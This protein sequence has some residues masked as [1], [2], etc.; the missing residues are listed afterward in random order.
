MCVCVHTPL[1]SNE[2]CFFFVSVEE[3]WS[4]ICDMSTSHNYTTAAG[5][6]CVCV[7]V[8]VHVNDASQLF[9]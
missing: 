7:C 8:C 1:D 4:K 5:I 2:V 3:N 9:L 6:V